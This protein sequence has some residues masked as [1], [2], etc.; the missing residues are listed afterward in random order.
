MKCSELVQLKLNSGA[1][2]PEMG[3]CLKVG[4]PTIEVGVLGFDKAGSERVNQS[5]AGA[6]MPLS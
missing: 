4:T 3:F 6:F 2:E 5:A 1:L